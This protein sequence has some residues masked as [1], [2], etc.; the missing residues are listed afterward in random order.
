MVSLRSITLL[1]VFLFCI[2]NNLLLNS[3]ARKKGDIIIIGG[4][5]GGGGHHE[6]EKHVQFIPIPYP[7]HQQQHHYQPMMFMP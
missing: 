2:S 6:E 4:H 1:T 5:G 3:E 7:V